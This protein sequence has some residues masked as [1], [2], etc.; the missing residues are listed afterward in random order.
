[1]GSTAALAAAAAS[2]VNI[3]IH[4]TASGPIKFFIFS[5]VVFKIC[6]GGQL[7]PECE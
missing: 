2:T 5:S 7:L 4:T 6:T 1:M 3:E